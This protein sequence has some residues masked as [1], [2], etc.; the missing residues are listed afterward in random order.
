MLA[1]A[2]LRCKTEVDAVTAIIRTDARIGQGISG[3]VYVSAVDQTLPIGGLDAP[4][5][6]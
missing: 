1:F 3:Y 2:M 4:E 6:Q 5:Q